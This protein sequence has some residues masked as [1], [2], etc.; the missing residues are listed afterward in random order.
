MK[1]S[2]SVNE[3]DVLASAFENFIISLFIMATIGLSLFLPSLA[4]AVRSY[5]DAGLWG[6]RN[7]K[8]LTTKRGKCNI[9]VFDICDRVTVLYFDSVT[10]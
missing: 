7:N 6:H 8:Y 1:K 4:M 10:N 5:Q 2:G 9:H 3:T